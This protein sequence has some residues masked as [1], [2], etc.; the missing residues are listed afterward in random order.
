MV[1]VTPPPSGGTMPTD[2]PAGMPTDLPT[3]LPAGGMPGG[4][5]QRVSG[6]VTA[7]AGT[8]IT[9][10]V[11]GQDGATSAQTVEVSADTTYTTTAAADASAIAVGLCASAQGD[12]DDSGRM[13][14]TSLA[15][16][17][18]GDDGCNQFAG[19]AG[20]MGRPAGNAA[21]NG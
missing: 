12:S 5:G 18:A 15:L 6:L 9:V 20:G 3:D 2:R 7:V 14:A 8:T 4:F 13:T 11:A 16:S 21:S 19:I 10:Q 1:P 17:V